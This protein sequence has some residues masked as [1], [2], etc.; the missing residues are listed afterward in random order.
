[1][2]KQ[3]YAFGSDTFEERTSALSHFQIALRFSVRHYLMALGINRNKV[4]SG[5][6]QTVNSNLV[7]SD[8]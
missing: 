7:K 5:L 6:G 3:K 2:D 4:K 1:L 8:P